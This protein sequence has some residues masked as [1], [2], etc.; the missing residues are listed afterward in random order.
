MCK[1][2]I[3]LVSFVLVL[4]LAG[5]AGAQI[6]TNPIPADGS[7][8]GQTWVVLTW[9][10]GTGAVSH[11]VYLGDNLADVQAGTGETFRGNQ[12]VTNLLIGFVGAPYPEGLVPGATYY[13]RIDEVEADGT[14][15]H[16]GQ[17]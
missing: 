14:T 12:T 13:W 5:N 9:S 8:L 4:G 7:V 3:Y 10:A 11:D 17:V 1:K 15:I 2:L 6:A 16:T